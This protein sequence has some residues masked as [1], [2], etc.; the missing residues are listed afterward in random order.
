MDIDLERIARG[1][2][3]PSGVSHITM[4]ES[5]TDAKA[6]AKFSP[7]AY[8]GICLLA[9]VS[10][11][12]MRVIAPHAIFFHGHKVDVKSCVVVHK[13]EYVTDDMSKQLDRYSV[14]LCRQPNTV[15]KVK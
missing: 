14:A 2:K 10:F 11:G 13:D 1:L 8:L 9:L 3:H 7:N 5:L 6:L 12:A 4:S 15:S